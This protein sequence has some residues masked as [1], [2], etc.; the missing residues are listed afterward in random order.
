MNGNLQTLPR[1][2]S[3]TTAPSNGRSGQVQPTNESSGWQQ[4]VGDGERLVSASAGAILIAQGL[5]RRDLLGVAI[6]GIGVAMAFRGATG[7][8]SMYQALGVDTAHRDGRESEAESERGTRV[9]QSFLINKSPE[10][11]YGY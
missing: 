4:N 5:A 6:A 9:T 2:R 11:L 3:L 7:H 1:D 8:C 10:E